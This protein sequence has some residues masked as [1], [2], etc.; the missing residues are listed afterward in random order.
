MV[1]RHNGK[2]EM[3]GEANFSAGEG[4]LNKPINLL[5]NPPPS[6]NSVKI[7]QNLNRTGTTAE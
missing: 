5:N 3:N 7:Y 2:A 6:H 1:T 4:N